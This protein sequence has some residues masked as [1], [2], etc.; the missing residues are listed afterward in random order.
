MPDWAQAR[1]HQLTEA[2]DG[3]YGDLGITGLREIGHGMDARVYRADSRRLG[4]VAIRVRT[5]G[6]S[7]AATSR[8]STPAA[9]SGRTTTS[10]ATCSRTASPC[11][12]CSSCT[13]TTR[14]W[15]FTIAQYIEADGSELP[16]SELGR[17]IRAIHDVP[18]PLRAGRSRA[19]YATRVA[20][21][22]RRGIAGQGAKRT[23]RPADGSCRG[24]QA[25]LAV[26]GHPV[27]RSGT[28]AGASAGG[29]PARPRRG[30][31]AV[32]VRRRPPG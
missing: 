18:V 14:A 12:R 7:P 31:P 10:A 13:P 19:C 1:H 4:T 26:G 8:S 9:S 28:R 21:T 16:G 22:G 24:R 15:T 5:T 29:V 20:S 30:H 17:L 11:L 3:Q 23:T 27:L 32:R 6:G 2:L 25:G